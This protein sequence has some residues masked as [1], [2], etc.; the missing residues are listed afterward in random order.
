[1]KNSLLIVTREGMGNAPQ[2]LQTV[3]V[4]N[5]FRTL[6][7][8]VV[9]C[10]ATD[11]KILWSVDLLKDYDGDNIR[12][13][14]TEN[15]LIDGDKLFC[16][17]GGKDAN[18]IALNKN[19]GSLIWNSKGNGEKSAYGSPV[20]IQVGEKKILVAQTE[21]S[22]LG[23]NSTNGTLLWKSEHTNQWSVHPNTPLFYNGFIYCVGGYGKGGVMLKLSTDGTSVTEIWH[24]A[25]LDNKMGGV[26]LINGKLYG[27][28]DKN[29]KLFCIDWITGAELFASNIMAPGNVIAAEGLIYGYGDNGVVSL[30]EPLAEQT[31][32]ISS[33]KVPFGSNQHWAHSVIANKK[34]YVRHGTSLMVY[35]IS[36]K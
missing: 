36:S 14:I 32:V 30:I 10:N 27:T 31:K 1:M 3:L 8:K 12:W 17:P 7:G 20:M 29:R 24:N 23:I 26:V 22:I 33:F 18:I 25:S 2:E 35:D 16:T 13:G 19:N 4:I 28:G 34:L 6:F 15:M 9:C 5:F 11:G 21:N